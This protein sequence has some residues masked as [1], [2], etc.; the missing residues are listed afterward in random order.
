[1]TISQTLAI[2]PAR[3]GSKRIPGKNI[4]PFAGVPMIVH[5]IRAAQEAGCFDQIIVSTDDEKIAEVARE[6]GASVPFIRPP[7]LAD[8]H[9]GTQEVIAHAIN[10]AI[11]QGW[12]LGPVCCIY[13][14]AP[15]IQAQDLLNGVALLRGNCQDF[16]FSAAAFDY[17]PYRGFTQSG[18]GVEMLFPEY[19]PIRSQDLPTVLHDA[20]QFYWG[21]SE[22][23]LE[24]QILFGP[25]ASPLLLPSHRVQD[26]DTPADW[27]RAELLW[28]LLQEE[29]ATS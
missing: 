23:W 8:D 19:F 29:E 22:V 2:I 11:S 14:T 12:K 26:I 5:S 6:Y 24:Q 28:Q 13:A 20:G 17:S 25:H 18:Q 7:E 16:V 3:G 4:R 21:T 27:Y 9:A 1:M 10:W 15:F